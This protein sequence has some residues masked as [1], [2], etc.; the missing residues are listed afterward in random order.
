MPKTI[1][2]KS[3]EPLEMMSGRKM[4]A[5]NIITANSS[6]CLLAY[7]E[8]GICHLALLKIFAKKIPATNE[9]NKAS[10]IML[11]NI[12]LSNQKKLPTVKQNANPLE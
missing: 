10:N 2:K 5:P 12:L 8:P 6:I 11:P 7:L 1:N 4:L 9:S 3:L